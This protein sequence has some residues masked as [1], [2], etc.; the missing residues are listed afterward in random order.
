M[1]EHEPL[2]S[3]GE[4][5]ERWGVTERQIRHLWATRQ[6]AAI[7]VGRHVRFASSD[8]DAFEAN[9]RVEATR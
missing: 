2:L 9:R 7:K 5:A 4:V 3:I 1:P 6:L 8:L